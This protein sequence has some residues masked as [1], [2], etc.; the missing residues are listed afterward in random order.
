MSLKRNIYSLIKGIK[1]GKLVL[2]QPKISSNKKKFLKKIKFFK[3]LILNKKDISYKTQ[4]QQIKFTKKIYKQIIKDIALKLNNIHK[5]NWDLKTWN[6][7]LGQWIHDYISIIID[8][9]HLIKPI[10]KKKI[11]SNHQFE[12]GKN[13][14][15]ISNDLSEFTRNAV[16]VNWNNKLNL[17]LLYLIKTKNFDKNNSYKILKKKINLENEIFNY[18]I[19]KIKI[20]ILKFIYFFFFSKKIVFY[21]SYIKNRFKVLKIFLKIKTIPLHYSFTFFNKKIIKSKIDLNLRKKIEFDYKKNENL[22]L[23]IIKFLFLE[24]FPKI[25]LEGFAKQKKISENSH[26][27]NKIERVFTSSATDDNSFKFWLA[28]KINKNKKIYFGSH[29]VGYN[30]YKENYDEEHQLKISNKLFIWG[31]KKYSR[32]MIPI[33]NFLINPQNNNKKLLTDFKILIVLPYIFLFKRRMSFFFLNALMNDFK[34]LENLLI[35]LKTKTSNIYLRPHPK[36]TF[37]EFNL[38]NFITLDKKKIT[39]IDNNKFENIEKKFSVLVFLYLSTEFTNSLAI[40]RPCMIFLNKNELRL[41]RKEVIKIFL[42]LHSVGILHFSGK[43]LANKL[44]ETSANIN[45]WWNNQ[46]TKKIKNEFRRNFSDSK[47][48]YNLLA[49]ILNK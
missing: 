16:T 34:Q 42:N 26:L 10:L 21:N 7:F 37:N 3:Y 9:L 27:P 2:Q 8:R 28:D 22:H 39:I 13:I 36:N 40:D 20:L 23:K 6:F 11:N 45:S 24:M 18:L 33:G 30:I 17:R 46:K 31:K 48:N 1:M 44:N 43:S 14:S 32:K 4:S 12:A 35:R 19:F 29:G 25:Y 49:E 47:F 41:Y 38:S 5:I 15:L